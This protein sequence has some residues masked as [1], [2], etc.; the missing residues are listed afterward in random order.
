M[1]SNIYKATQIALRNMQN[2]KS[3]VQLTKQPHHQME[4]AALYKSSETVR[5][6]KE[7]YIHKAIQQLYITKG[8]VAIISGI[9]QAYHP[10]DPNT[11][12]QKQ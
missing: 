10:I 2:T 5:S 4:A 9:S 1:T 12:D 6:F 3:S 11:N 7:L 8:E